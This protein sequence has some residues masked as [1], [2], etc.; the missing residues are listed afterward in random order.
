MSKGF[1]KRAKQEIYA[2]PGQSG[3]T[4]ARKL[5]KS[6]EVESRAQNPEMSL[7]A[8]LTKHYGDIEVKRR[9]VDGLYRYYPNTYSFPSVNNSLSGEAAAVETFGDE[10][11]EATSSNGVLRRQGEAAEGLSDKIVITGVGVKGYCRFAQALVETGRCKSL[12]EAFALMLSQGREAI[13]RSLS[14]M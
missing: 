9:K 6:G 2:H 13:K 3:Q 8:T 7:V 11:A 10:V 1:L 14:K 12:D 5:L 4:I